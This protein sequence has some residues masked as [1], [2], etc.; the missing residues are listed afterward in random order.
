MMTMKQTSFGRWTT[1][2]L[3]LLFVL[4]PAVEA[5]AITK[6]KLVQMSK[7]GLEDDE[8][9]VLIDAS[10]KD[11]LKVTK[12]EIG[13]L[14]LQGVSD[15]VIEHLKKTGRVVDADGAAPADAG[16]P[17]PP[18]AGDA[19][20]D[21]AP[22]DVAPAGGDVSL[23]PAPADEG[24][25]K[26]PMTEEELDAEMKRRME[27]QKAEEARQRRIE[28]MARRLPEAEQLVE[29]GD[30]MEAA[31][32]YLEFLSLDP[33]PV[34]PEWYEAKFGLAKALYQEGILSGASTPLFEVVTA[35]AEQP[36]FKEAFGMLQE[37][38]KQIGYRPPALEELTTLYLGDLNP[39]F[40]DEFNYYMG[41]FF[42]DYEKSDLAIEYLNKV[43]EGA[44]DYPEA[45][46][47][48]GIAKLDP[49]VNDTAGALRDFEGAIR[50]GEA[51][52]GGNQEILQLGYLALARTFYEVGFYDVALFYY[53]KLPS[54]SS[55]NAEATFEQAWTYFLKNDYRRALGTFH[56][57]H[58]PYYGKWYFPDL[59]ILEATVYLNLCMFE[60]SK[61][62]LAEFQ[63]TY[64][65]KQPRLAE[66]LAETSEP[67][68]LWYAM[69]TA[70]D[71]EEGQSKL[72][73][74][75]ANAVLDDLEF[76]NTYQVIQRLKN[77]K[78]ALEQNVESLGDFGASVLE[79][80]DQQLDTKVE[81]GGILVQQ[82]LGAI[83]RELTDWEIKATQISFDIDAEDKAQLERR[84]T[85]PDWQPPTAEGGTTFLVVADDWQRWDFEGEYWL[86]EV[87][88][89]RSG[90]RSQ[91]LEQ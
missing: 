45:L 89:Y 4:I 47:V 25:D 83:D 39:E 88:N 48:K 1:A 76:Y 66:F 65:D 85:N 7:I 34:S 29:S 75:F 28:G 90:L 37:L 79:R 24:D 58:S 70:F 55:R 41:K 33:D 31:R 57:L 3:A 80:V 36:H 12:E 27:A 69:M 43:S 10:G 13:E 46:Y 56:T 64:L 2:L 20:A 26:K 73:R 60:Q 81:E 54:N 71:K 32:L 40:Q 77:E 63:K 51:E 91:C 53:Q 68:A 84:L 67:R 16:D 15:A 38:T 18:D 19:P 8:L 62:A 35:G 72:P 78:A 52:P 5:S 82:K 23:E 74:I 87:S 49:S 59:Y 86:D 50:A 22:A 11:E 21:V 17:T 61:I 42:F 30:N 6:D 14:R 9:I 44:P